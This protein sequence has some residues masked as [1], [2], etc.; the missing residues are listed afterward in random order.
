MHRV[1]VTVLAL[2]E[3]WREHFQITYFCYKIIQHEAYAYSIKIIHY[4]IIQKN[5]P[6]R[7]GVKSLSLLA[8]K[9]EPT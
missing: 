8:S 9:W 5:C 1:R 2:R 6:F 3:A 4:K 7:L